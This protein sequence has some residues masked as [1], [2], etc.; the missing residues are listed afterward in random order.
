MVDLAK[1]RAQKSKQ[2]RTRYRGA[3]PTN[4]DHHGNTPPPPPP[5]AT[6]N[7]N[8][9]DALA[10]LNNAYPPHLAVRELNAIYEHVAKRING[11]STRPLT[12]DELVAATGPVAEIIHEL[13]QH[14]IRQQVARH[15]FSPN[16]MADATPTLTRFL[17]EVD[18]IIREGNG[19]RMQEYLV[20]EPP[21]ADAYI[22]VINEVRRNYPKGSEDALEARCSTLL[23]QA[24]E[25]VDGA[26]WTAFI[27]FIVQYFV[28]IRDFSEDNL[29]D[30][31]TLLSELVQ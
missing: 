3:L 27:K 21:Y 26:S 9:P 24:R 28:F 6:V 15:S 8:I 31:Y 14:Y 25:G 12:F 10:I 5:V 30:T 18:Q 1:S 11:G 19:P 22:S 29:L 13:K 23:P 4:D 7:V 2:S 17:D 20:I 16:T